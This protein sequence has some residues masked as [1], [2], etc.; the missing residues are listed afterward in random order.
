MRGDEQD[1]VTAPDEG[2]SKT[3]AVADHEPDGGLQGR[4]WSG[5]ASSTSMDPEAGTGDNA[6]DMT[7]LWCPSMPRAGLARMPFPDIFEVA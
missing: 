6:A 3:Y 7:L 1:V 2:G 5:N 4:L